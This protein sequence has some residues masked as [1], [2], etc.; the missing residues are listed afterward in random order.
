MKKVSEVLFGGKINL[1]DMNQALRDCPA[2]FKNGS[3]WSTYVGKCI[4]GLH[5]A[6]WKW[7]IPSGDE[8]GIWLGR[9]A[10]LLYSPKFRIEDRICIGGWMLSEMLKEIPE[11]P[12]KK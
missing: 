9:L 2:E 7:K 10:F 8:R 5:T 4:N 1:L 3:D 12:K 6:D 11:Y